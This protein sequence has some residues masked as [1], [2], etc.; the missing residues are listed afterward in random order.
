MCEEEYN[1]CHNCGYKRVSKGSTSPFCLPC[2]ISIY[3][4]NM[5]SDEIKEKAKIV[6]QIKEK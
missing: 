2:L 4:P 5:I 3:D 1:N 6:E